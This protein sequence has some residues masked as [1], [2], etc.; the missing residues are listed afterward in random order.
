MNT[1][2]LALMILVVI[3]ATPLTGDDK[4]CNKYDNKFMTLLHQALE[5]ECNEGAKNQKKCKRL[6]SKVRYYNKLRTKYCY[7]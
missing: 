6:L 4:K 3:L 5:L 1:K 7:K 2:N